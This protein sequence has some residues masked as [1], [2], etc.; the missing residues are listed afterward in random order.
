MNSTANPATT[1]TA[2]P[3]WAVGTVI[4]IVERTPAVDGFADNLVVPNEV[5][6]N[7]QKVLVSGEHPVQ[8]HP[9]KSDEV[10]LV[11]LILMAKRIVI[12]QEDTKVAA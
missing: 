9:I 8:V 10:V 12:A 2:K 5:R 6:I 3:S 1:A 11:T 4:E 7:G